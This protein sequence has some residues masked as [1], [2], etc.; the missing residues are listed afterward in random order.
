MEAKKRE[1]LMEAKTS[2]GSR[3]TGGG[4]G[5]GPPYFG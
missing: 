2:G 1:I 3:V 4:D 5:R